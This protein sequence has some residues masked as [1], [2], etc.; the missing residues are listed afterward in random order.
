MATL[1][2]DDHENIR[3]I[4][5]DCR[6]FIESYWAWQMQKERWHAQGGLL[7]TLTQEDLDNAGMSDLRVQDLN[8]VVYW[9]TVNVIDN[10]DNTVGTKMNH[11]GSV[12]K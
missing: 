2:T 12:V 8:D 6:Y 11:I 4:A 10:L 3:D 1:T 7:D 9:F 5:A